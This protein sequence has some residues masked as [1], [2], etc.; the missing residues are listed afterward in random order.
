MKALL[1]LV[2]TSWWGNRRYEGGDGGVAGAPKEEEESAQESERWDEHK[3]DELDEC[4]DFC[5]HARL[6]GGW[7]HVSR[8]NK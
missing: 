2:W 1:L 8:R 4:Q 7:V 3:L 6:K 5:E